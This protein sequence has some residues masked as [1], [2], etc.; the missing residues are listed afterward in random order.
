MSFQA[1][2]TLHHYKNC[3]K[4]AQVWNQLYE[5]LGLHYIASSQQLESIQFSSLL[6]HTYQGFLTFQSF[7]W[8]DIIF[9][10]K[11]GFLAII[12]VFSACGCHHVV[13]EEV[14]VRA[15]P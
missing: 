11:L 6:Q 14:V 12:W 13:V 10:L 8:V 7:S 4:F 9:F 15:I 1:P 3:Y 5:I 2:N